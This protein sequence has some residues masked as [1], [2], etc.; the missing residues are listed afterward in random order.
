V[1]G[2]EWIRNSLSFS[3]ILYDLATGD[4]ETVGHNDPKRVDHP[5]DAKIH[6]NL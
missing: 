5:K 1:Y 6:E 3:K 2:S 4:Q